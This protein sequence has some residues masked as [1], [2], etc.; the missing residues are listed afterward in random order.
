KGSPLAR[1][2]TGRPRCRSISPNASL[3]GLGQ[4]RRRPQIRLAASSRWRAPPM[5][6]S[7]ERIKRR[8]MEDNP[9]TPSSPIPT[10]DSQR[11]CVQA[12]ALAFM[13]TASMRVLILGGTTEASGLTRLLA[14]DPR[15]EATVSLAG[16]TANPKAQP[17]AMRIGG[18]GGADGL[19]AR[20][21]QNAAQT[22][23]DTTHH[24]ADSIPS[25]PV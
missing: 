24:H 6:S 7:A 5:T 14:A 23:N 20:L 11:F 4:A 25:N 16:R 17:V 1:I 22:R 8:A 10:I 13:E 12:A 3:I 15:F 19:V 21:N 9:S 18:F 2:A